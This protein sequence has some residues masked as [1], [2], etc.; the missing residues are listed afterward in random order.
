MLRKSARA[1]ARPGKSKAAA[2]SVEGIAP[3]C[4]D[5]RPVCSFLG[6]CSQLS[7][8]EI[9]DAGEGSGYDTAGE[10]D[11]EIQLKAPERQAKAKGVVPS[12]GLFICRS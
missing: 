1:Q 6:V 9:N 5:L 10:V 7:V 3:I 2:G 4:V 12:R 11:S 8:S